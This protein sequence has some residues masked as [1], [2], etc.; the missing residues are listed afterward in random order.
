V[1]SSYTTD[2]MHA[3]APDGRRIVASEHMLPLLVGVVFGVAASA[4]W[5]DRSWAGLV[6]VALSVISATVALSIGVWGTTVMADRHRSLR[7]ERAIAAASRALLKRDVVDPVGSAL[8]AL[9]EGARVDSVFLETNVDDDHDEHGNTQSVRDILFADG[10]E[11][12]R[13]ELTGWRISAPAQ[14][15]LG[16]GEVFR[17]EPAKLEPATRTIYRAALV[18]KEVLA[19][20]TIDGRWVGSVGFTTSDPDRA[21]EADEE[22]LLRITAEMIGTY[23][24]RR[25]DRAHLEE[26]V[27]SKDEFIASV[28]HEVRTPLTAVLGFAHELNDAPE[29]FDAEERSDL[30]ELIA[31]QSQE[32]AN[33]VDDLLIAARAEAGTIVI[34]SEDVAVRAVVGDVLASHSGRVDFSLEADEDLMVH[35]D[36][37]RVRQILRNLLTNADRYGGEMVKINVRAHGESVVIQVRDD[38]EGI[39][40]RKR[41]HVFE[42]YARAAAGSNM[43]ESVGLGLSVARKLAELMKGSLEL[44]RENGWTVFSLALPVA[45]IVTRRDRQPV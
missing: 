3:P 21:W 10:V 12:G 45:P 20:I 19:P 42:P 43:P 41:D 4:L 16:R 7:I 33:I 1:A 18:A 24:E 22:R 25:E 37:G 44:S 5:A 39:P 35:A 23:W 6:A 9:I 17:V 30:V 40:L 15:A 38:G 11:P 8:S 29:R 32:V 27:R 2:G 28:S 26:I 36:P 31:V 34:A 13:W 14:A